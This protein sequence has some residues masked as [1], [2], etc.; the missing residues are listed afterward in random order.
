[1][2]H[3]DTLFIPPEKLFFVFTSKSATGRSSQNMPTT[4]GNAAQNRSCSY[5]LFL[6]QNRSQAESPK[7]CPP[8]VET[9]PRTGHV[10]ILHISCTARNSAQF[11]PFWFIELHFFPALFQ[12]KDMQ[13]KANNF[14][15]LTWWILSLLD[16]L[17]GSSWKFNQCKTKTNRCRNI[18]V[19]QFK[20]PVKQS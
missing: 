12:H 2:E 9:Q 1:M 18:A 10:G 8:L 15:L 5:F 4:G 17:H 6:R 3:G 14:R 7:T 11:L 20:G 16:N 19:F 13:K